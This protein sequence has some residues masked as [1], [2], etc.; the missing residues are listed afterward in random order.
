MFLFVKQMNLNLD[1]PDFNKLCRKGSSYTTGHHQSV[2]QNLKCFSVVPKCVAHMEKKKK[3]STGPLYNG[4]P[5][6]PIGI[7]QKSHRHC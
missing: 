5:Q 2:R 1:L 4:F 6:E 3:K 7:Q